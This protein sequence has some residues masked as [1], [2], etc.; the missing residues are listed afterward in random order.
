MLN[1]ES[2][3]VYFASLLGFAAPTS[4]WFLDVGEPVMKVLVLVGQFAVAIATV[5]YISFKCRELLR[6]N[7]TKQ[8]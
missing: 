5:V 7:R 4:S 8:K 2:V 3:K 1:T 6:R